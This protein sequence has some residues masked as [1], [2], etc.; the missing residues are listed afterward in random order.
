M[1]KYVLV[2]IMIVASVAFV[3]A[4]KSI[5][6]YKKSEAMNLKLDHANQVVKDF[7]KKYGVK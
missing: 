2:S 5:Y 7:N 6:S 1:R 4:A 3:Y